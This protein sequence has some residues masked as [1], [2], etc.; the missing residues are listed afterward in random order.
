MQWRKKGSP[1][2]SPIDR[3]SLAWLQAEF[4]RAM[5][6][7]GLAAPACLFPAR[8]FSVHRNNL[9]ASLIDVLRA[10]YPVIE[11]LVGEEFFVSAARLFAGAYPPLSPVLIE[12]GE[13]FPAFLE[14]FEPARGLPYLADVA[15]LEWLRHAAYHAADRTPMTAASLAAVP[16]EQAESLTFA[17]HPSASLI[18][19]PYPLVSIWETNAF[20]ARVRPI[21]PELPGEAAL[22]IRPQLQVNVLRLDAAEHAF[23]AALAAGQTLADVAG[24][25]AAHDGF[26]LGPSLA[27]LIAAG[28][29]SDFTAGPTQA[30]D[31]HHA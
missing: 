13:R 31:S 3:E 6:D 19:S 20:D 15:R 30:G 14:S 29:F 12:Y 21:G 22:V 27:K 17:F 18:A 1:M 5:L 9:Y 25:A 2:R 23:A 28:T 26:D 8:R 11:R 4:S 24:K 7:T 10:R 16:P